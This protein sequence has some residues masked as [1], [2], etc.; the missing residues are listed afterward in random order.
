MSRIRLLNDQI[1][2]ISKEADAIKFVLSVVP[3]H[4]PTVEGVFMNTQAG[5]RNCAL[6]AE[7]AVTF[8]LGDKTKTKSLI[9]GE[10]TEKVEWP[11]DP[12]PLGTGKGA[13]G[14]MLGADGH[15][16]ALL[17]EGDTYALF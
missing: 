16:M 13:E 9:Y 8:L 5:L 12:L 4:K 2:T 15:N 1:N 11:Y 7:F 3:H 14:V 10:P 17:R 6:I